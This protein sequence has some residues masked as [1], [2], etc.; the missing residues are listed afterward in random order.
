MLKERV[1]VELWERIENIF[2]TRSNMLDNIS[3]ENIIIQA[4]EKL[5]FFQ[6][7]IKKANLIESEF[8]ISSQ[9]VRLDW[10]LYNILYN[11]IGELYPKGK[12][13]GLEFR[14]YRIIEKN[15]YTLDIQINSGEL[16]DFTRGLGISYEFHLK[17]ERHLIIC[18]TI[19]EQID[20]LVK[21]I[22][23]LEPFVQR[24]KG[25]NLNYTP[26][27]IFACTALQAQCKFRLKELKDQKV[28]EADNIRDSDKSLKFKPLEYAIFH[29]LKEEA[30]RFPKFI[31]DKNREFPKNDIKEMSATK[32]SH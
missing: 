6:K 22:I 15:Y 29:R 12:L 11:V 4:E 20:F 16:S 9:F 17:I 32:Y 19:E 24:E 25:D 18:D 7:N 26:L 27:N 14:S 8:K 1:S 31:E 23:R 10:F 28:I 2:S 3:K 30:K 13:K 21:E 5:I